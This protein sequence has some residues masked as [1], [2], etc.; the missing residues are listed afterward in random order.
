VKWKGWEDPTDYTWEPAANMAGSE[1]LIEEFEKSSGSE[2]SP[3]EKKSAKRKKTSLPPEESAEKKKR[4]F[5]EPES[6]TMKFSDDKE[7]TP[8]SDLG[9]V[10]CPEC[11]RIF[12]SS[13]AFKKH[14]KEDHGK[15]VKMPK[16][17]KADSSDVEGTNG[18]GLIMRNECEEEKPKYK[19]GP[20]SWKMKTF[21]DES[22]PDDR[23]TNNKSEVKPRKSF[24][25]LSDSSDDEYAADPLSDPKPSDFES[26]FKPS[27]DDKSNDDFSYK[28]DSDDENADDNIEPTNVD[29]LIGNS[30]DEN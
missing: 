12:L 27:S 3:L 22:L 5:T 19:P 4:L 13:Q 23:Y 10:L 26:L 21:L 7:S 18:G 6:N 20:K 2:E 28:K 1:N 15:S 25:D 9:V 8:E 17:K 11:N 29:E 30:D 24:V 16:I 14:E